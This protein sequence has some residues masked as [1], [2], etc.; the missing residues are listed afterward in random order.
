MMK[1]LH[2]QLKFTSSHQTNVKTFQRRTSS[3]KGTLVSVSVSKSNKF[4]KA[5]R[6]RDDLMF[7]EPSTEENVDKSTKRITKVLNEMEM[8]WTEHQK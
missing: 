5:K 6:I 7:N 3:R 8:E 1:Q 4:F 2:V